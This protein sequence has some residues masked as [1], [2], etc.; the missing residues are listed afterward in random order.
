M[1]A[2]SYPSDS[3]HVRVEPREVSPGRVQLSQ[4]SH[5]PLVSLPFFRSCSGLR[6][7]ELKL[8]IWGPCNRAEWSSHPQA[9]IAFQTPATSKT[10]APSSQ[11]ICCCG[12][13]GWPWGT[14]RNEWRRGHA[15]QVLPAVLV[16]GAHTVDR[17]KDA[18]RPP[19]PHCWEKS[20]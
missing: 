6:V 2:K 3:L 16:R 20:N 8:P 17:V 4:A 15:A 1:V 12:D 9:P 18:Q 13:P 19:P 5:G 14:G 7:P 10:T 11:N